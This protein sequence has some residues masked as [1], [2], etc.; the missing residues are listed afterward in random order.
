MPEGG[1][2]LSLPLLAFAQEAK[3]QVSLNTGAHSAFTD[4]ADP[5]ASLPWGLGDRRKHKTT[6]PQ[7]ARHFTCSQ[8]A[9]FSLLQ[10]ISELLSL[11]QP[12]SERL[13]AAANQ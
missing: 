1:L 12:I 7:R 3:E 6:S 5:A 2:G 9:S 10:P 4:E 13:S 11:L 8:S